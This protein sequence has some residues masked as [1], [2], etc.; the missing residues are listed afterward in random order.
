MKHLRE[1]Y[2]QEAQASKCEIAELREDVV[3]Q[4]T[5]VRENLSQVW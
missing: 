1:Q 2:E 4:E 3:T 5:I